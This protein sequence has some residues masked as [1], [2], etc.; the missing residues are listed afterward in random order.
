M[1][2]L[3]PRQGMEALA[4]LL[5][6]AGLPVVSAAPIL[7][8]VLLRGKPAPP[9]LAEFAPAQPAVTTFAIAKVSP[10]CRLHVQ[11]YACSSEGRIWTV[12]CLHKSVMLPGDDHCEVAVSPVPLCCRDGAVLHSVWAEGA[13]GDVQAWQRRERSE[14]APV[15][16]LENALETSSWRYRVAL[17]RHTVSHGLSGHP[18]MPYPGPDNTF[19]SC[20]RT[21]H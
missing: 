21:A 15:R 6:G 20:A 7:W 5:A 10:P 4:S 17:D 18:C 11:A 14:P 9:F 12:G 8:D 13:L 3:A 1:G 16:L 19:F 2:T